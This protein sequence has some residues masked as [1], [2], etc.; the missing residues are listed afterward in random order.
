MLESSREFCHMPS[1][2]GKRCQNHVW[3][4]DT[5]QQTSDT[6][7]QGYLR[8]SISDGTGAS[9]NLRLTS[10][11]TTGSR[12]ECTPLDRNTRNTTFLLSGEL[13][14]V[15]TGCLLTLTHHNTEIVIV[16]RANQTPSPLSASLVDWVRGSLISARHARQ[17]VSL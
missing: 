7:T 6:G 1:E 9:N 14:I 12:E 16:I 17:A 15:V 11:G 10:P 5:T 3:Q 13:Q 4:C 8:G 2:M